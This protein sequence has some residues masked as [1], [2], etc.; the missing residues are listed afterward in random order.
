MITNEIQVYIRLISH[1]DTSPNSPFKLC[2]ASPRLAYGSV[3]TSS[4]NGKVPWRPLPSYPPRW[5]CNANGHHRV[6]L[7][8]PP[9][10]PPPPRPT[11]PGLPPAMVSHWTSG[12]GGAQKGGSVLVR[13]SILDIPVSSFVATKS[14]PLQVVSAGASCCFHTAGSTC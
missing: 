11:P 3:I 8:S 5:V 9:L 6:G 14:P 4:T 7:P 12:R 1:G 2:S 10:P 13:S